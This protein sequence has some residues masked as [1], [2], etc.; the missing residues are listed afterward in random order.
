MAAEIK[1]SQIIRR[2]YVPVVGNDQGPE[3]SALRPQ[4]SVPSRGWLRGRRWAAR[5]V[6]TVRL[7]AGCGPGRWGGAG[8]QVERRRHLIGTNNGAAATPSGRSAAAS[9]AQT[10]HESILGRGA[11]DSASADR[12]G[13]LDRGR[14]QN[15]CWFWSEPRAITPVAAGIFSGHRRVAASAMDHPLSP[16]TRWCCIHVEPLFT[17]R[18]WNCRPPPN[19]PGPLDHRRTRRVGASERAGNLAEQSAAAALNGWLPARVN[20]GI[21]IGRLRP[22]NQDGR[23]RRHRVKRSPTW[24]SNGLRRYWAPLRGINIADQEPLG[25]S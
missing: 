9:P 2:N 17:C 19:R 5:G 16:N 13:A 21:R 12:A 8:A 1:P 3:H 20:R 11:F 6:V 18:W 15:R 25:W 10:I 23:E 14:R 4:N 7:I 22:S 24:A